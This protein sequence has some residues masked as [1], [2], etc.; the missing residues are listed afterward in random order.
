ML[1]ANIGTESLYLF[2][3]TN[4]KSS[5]RKKKRKKN[6]GNTIE[7]SKLKLSL[8]RVIILFFNCIFSENSISIELPAT[9][10][11]S[12]N[13]GISKEPLKNTAKSD[14]VSKYNKKTLSIH[15]DVT[16]NISFNPKN[17]QCFR[18]CFSSATGS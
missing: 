17:P 6:S 3:K 8:K 15:F 11:S 12:P 2:L 14:A 4:A 5:S 16:P 18:K 9:L 7:A 10:I 13:K 1:I